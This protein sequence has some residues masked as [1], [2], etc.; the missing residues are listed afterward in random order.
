MNKVSFVVDNLATH[1]YQAELLLFSLDHFGKQSKDNILVHCTTRVDTTFLN[2]L[3]INGY[4]YKIIEPFLDGKYCNK[5][6]QLEAF[7]NS[8]EEGGV[9][10]L[11]TD[12][13]VLEPLNIPDQSSFCAKNVDGPNPPLETINAIFTKANIQCPPLVDTDW[14]LDDSRTIA[15]NFNGGFYYIP[16]KYVRT[17]LENWKKWAT[18]LFQ[19][20]ELF[21]N[22]YQ[23]MHTDQISM[24]LATCDSQIPY[25]AIA[26]NYNCPIHFVHPQRSF[27]SA[28]PVSNL[29]YHREISSFGTLKKDNASNDYIRNAIQKANSA[30][31]SHGKF[32]FFDKYKK[33]LVS[34]ILRTDK[35]EKLNS[36]LSNFKAKH[37]KKLKFILH[38]GSPKT[39][40]TS[41][42]FFL[43]RHQN[44]LNK[45]G[46][47]YPTVYIETY[48]PKHQ[49][50]VNSFLN[51]DVDLLI[52][53]FNLIFALIKNDIHTVILSTEGIFNHWFD[54]SQEAKSFL[55]ILSEQ[56]DLD[57]WVWF[58]STTSFIN[59][60]YIQYIKNGQN[61]NVTCYGKNLSLLEMLQDE[62]FVKHLDYLGFVYETEALFKKEHVK[63]FAY[64][65]EIISMVCKELGLKVDITSIKRENTSMSSGVGIELLRIINRIPLNP[66]EKGECVALLTKMDKILR[67]YPQE[68][69]CNEA[70][71][72]II[73]E[74]SSLGVNILESEYN[75][76]LNDKSR[77]D[78]P[79]RDLLNDSQ[80]SICSEPEIQQV[81]T[82]TSFMVK[83]KQRLQ[84]I[85]PLPIYKF[86]RFFY[87]LRKAAYR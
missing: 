74:L 76:S 69:N 16:Y 59:S 1:Y 11:D 32:N 62:W 14:I 75:L 82:K 29:H 35:T 83:L 27:N 36:F 66:V 25:L 19:K 33:S 81:E 73:F 67:C 49:W 70:A 87:R 77:T 8:N 50:L 37:Q 39:G 23:I 12:M 86:F 31:A 46:Y 17:L 45:L 41:L 64:D 72:Q 60:L 80:K 4:Q 6:Q 51:N 26:S 13:F 55:V 65:G 79:L 48:A 21:E 28:I 15:T 68:K 54:Y 38:A 7:N 18:W 34:S 42:Q 43:D 10:L 3:K 40:T 5:I 58:R 47:L 78:V 52:E 2:F 84:K 71:N 24:A 53:K 57:L 44:E 30:I 20:P 56:F 22:P 9:F 85:M 63:L 61:S